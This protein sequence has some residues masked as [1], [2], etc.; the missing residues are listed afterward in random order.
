MLNRTET[1]TNE[2][3]SIARDERRTVE[4]CGE[5]RTGYR[6]ILAR[7]HEGHHECHTASNVHRWK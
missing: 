3:D 6:C 7:G 4:L 5:Q 1:T 2:S